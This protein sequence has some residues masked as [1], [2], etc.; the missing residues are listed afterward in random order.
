[1]R[2]QRK[3]IAFHSARLLSLPWHVWVLLGEFMFVWLKW[4]LP[5]MAPAHTDLHL[6]AIVLADF[7]GL[8]A[9]PFLLAGGYLLLTQ[10]RQQLAH[11]RH[12]IHT[13]GLFPHR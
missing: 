9:A 2:S 11:W 13:L 1:M 6:V 4:I 10:K 8:F 5:A 3:S 7:A 12:A